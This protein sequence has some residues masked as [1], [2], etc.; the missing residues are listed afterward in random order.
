MA[1]EEFGA[2]LVDSWLL[3]LADAAKPCGEDLEYDNAFLELSQAA[4]GKPETQFGPGEPP[5]W[6]E[7]RSLAEALL[8]R[9]RDLRIA[10][11][12]VRA[13]V[14]QTGFAA[15]PQGLRLLHGLLSTFW[16]HLHPMLDADDGDSFARVNVLAVLP[17][18]DGLLGDLRKALLLSQRGVGEVRVR[19]IEIA[20]GLATAKSGESTLTR[21][22][23]HQMLAAAVKQ[24]AALRDLSP[25]ALAQ[26]RTLNAVFNERFGVGT[27]ADLKP[28]QAL[29]NAVESL[30]PVIVVDTPPI[31][32][33]DADDASGAG[34]MLGGVP[35][36]RLSGA[37]RSRDD[38][39]RAIDMICEYLEQTEPASPAPL[40]L[41]RARRMI[42]RSFLQ[43]L[44][45]LAPESLTEVAR[46]M[47]V[48]PDTIHLEE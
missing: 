3:P 12:W 42:N 14:N 47:G 39:V 19:S 40:L 32:G 48:D 6:R 31:E 30:M 41:R 17:Q 25:S 5:D 43:L 20:L 34:G 7:V 24:D 10:V 13:C 29:V 16:E 1:A 11:L 35:G 36:A 45:E 15:L 44:K 9:T 37:V 4:Q 33:V 23:V 2:T 26:L 8:Q 18:N 38:A 22:Q 46:V 21:D 28:I 27:V